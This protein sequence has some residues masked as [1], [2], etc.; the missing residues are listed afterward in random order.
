[1]T[2]AFDTPPGTVI[3]LCVPY[4][5]PSICATRPICASDGIGSPPSLPNTPVQ[6]PA[7]NTPPLGQYQR[8]PGIAWAV[9][10]GLEKLIT[11]P[12]FTTVG[13]N[14]CSLALSTMW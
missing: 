9:P 4:H 12:P 7:K 14:H 6:T 13:S 5:T 10:F 8:L 2:G 1:M 11:S 3:G